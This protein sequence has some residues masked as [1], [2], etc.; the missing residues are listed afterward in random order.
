MYL[1]SILHSILH[2]ADKVNPV[3]FL[4]HVSLN[5]VPWQHGAGEPGLDALDLAGV[6]PAILPQNVPCGNA[7]GTQAV[8]DGCLEA[9][10]ECKGQ[11]LTLLDIHT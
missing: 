10:Q 11:Q 4:P 3:S 1:V 9:W 5:G 6:I 2:L 7:I 8:Q